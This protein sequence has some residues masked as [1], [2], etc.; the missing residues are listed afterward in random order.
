LSLAL[1]FGKKNGYMLWSLFWD[2]R[3]IRKW[4]GVIALKQ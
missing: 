4:Y 3:I 1:G 2:S